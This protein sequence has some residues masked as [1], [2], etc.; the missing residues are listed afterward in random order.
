M[1]KS[2][3]IIFRLWYTIIRKLIEQLLNKKIVADSPTPIFESATI[4]TTLNRVPIYIVY[5]NVPI[6]STLGTF[7]RA[8]QKKEG[9]L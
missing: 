1:N 9:I 8:S 5:H 7:F 4:A 2:I 3:D 6:E